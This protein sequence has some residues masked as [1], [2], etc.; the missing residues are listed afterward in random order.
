MDR[1]VIEVWIKFLTIPDFM[2][3]LNESQVEVE[4]Y[5]KG[6]ALAPPVIK[7]V[8]NSDQVQYERFEPIKQELRQLFV[9]IIGEV[10]SVTKDSVVKPLSTWVLKHKRIVNE[11]TI[12]KDAAEGDEIV[13]K[14]LDKDLD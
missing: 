12:E 6:E 13:A 7:V 9:Q 1:N 14:F 2:T 3:P 5:L 10:M 4:V 11:L 8:T